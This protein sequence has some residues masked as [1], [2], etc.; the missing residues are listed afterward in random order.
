[1]FKIEIGFKIGSEKKRDRVYANER[2][3][4]REEV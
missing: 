3:R 1:M 2:E 4:E